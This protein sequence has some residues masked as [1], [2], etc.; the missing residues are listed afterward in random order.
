MNGY[1]TKI[2]VLMMSVFLAQAVYAVKQEKTDHPL[3]SAYAGS[4]IYSKDI[5]QFD[6]YRVFKG[7]DKETKEYRT[8]VLEGKITKILYKNPPERSVLELYRNY[9]SALETE[10]VN[11]LYECNQS[12]MECVDGYVGAHL[13]QRFGIYAIGNKSGRYLFARLDQEDQLAY[14]VLAVGNQ[15]TD[16]H[17]IEMKK[18]DTGNVAL[19]LAALSADLDTQGFVVLEGIYFDTD[20]TELTPASKPALDEVANLL[21]QRPQ[22]SLYV[23]G[24]TDMQGSISHNMQ[25][26]KGRANTVV[27][28]LVQEYGIAAERLEGHGV[29]PLAP[30]ASNHQEGGRSKN[31]RVVL[32]QR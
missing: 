18:M 27:S 10:G 8:E 26:S 5:K 1:G 2:G 29:G 16:V 31:R 25:L 23:V 14:L 32:V 13:R 19:N 24:H 30:V 11:I 15:N 17:V 7:W 9:Q 28:T 22:L 21:Q 4:S 6:E 3:V 20:K 12:N